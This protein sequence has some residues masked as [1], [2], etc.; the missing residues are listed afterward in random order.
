ML[1]FTFCFF[2]LSIG[3]DTADVQVMI[4]LLEDVIVFDQSFNRRDGKDGCVL[5]ISCLRFMVLDNVVCDHRHP[6]LGHI[7][8]AYINPIC[9]C[10][11]V[12][13]EITLHRLDVLNMEAKN[14]V[15]ED[16]I[17]DE[18][19]MY[20]FSEEHFCGLCDFSLRLSVDL[21]TRCAGKSEEL[22]LL[23]MPNNVL[24][25][26][27][28]LTAVTL[29]NDEDNFLVLI[30]IHNFCVLRTLHSVRHLLHRCDDELP[31]FVLHLFYK[32][33]SSISGINRTGFEFVELFCG[34][35][36]QVLPVYKEDN[37]FDIGVGCEDL[38]CLK[39]SQRLSCAGCMPN[40]SV[41]VSERGLPDKSLYCIHL[42][43]THHHEQLV[44]VIQDGVS[45]QHLDN[46]VS[47]KEGDRE[48]FQIGDTHIVEVRPE[49]GKTVKHIS[50]GVGKVFCINAIGHNEKLNEVVQSVVG[51]LFIAHHL[52]DSFSNIYA[53]PLQLHLNERKSIDKD[54]HII[55]ID[56]L[57]NNGCL[58][59]YLK[60]VLCVVGIEE[61]EVHFRSVL[62]LQHELISK[63]FCALE[64]RFSEHNVEHSLPFLRCQRV[65]E[66][67]SIED[68]KLCFEVLNQS[69][70][71][72]YRDAGVALLIELF[73]KLLF[74]GCFTLVCHIFI[75]YT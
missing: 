33:I 67:R 52:V 62:T 63:Y 64:N 18:I 72:W 41:A 27:T 10:G 34:L 44:R 15:V 1:I 49:E 14:I 39:G 16:S 47:G 13:V 3:E 4:D 54:R 58:V 8:F 6:F 20:A 60:N 61:G 48:L 2:V 22:S 45:R 21:K 38:C 29:I 51:M 59:C 55:T 69:V 46:M 30:G 37:L 68:C 56:I 74:K 31:V 26:I 23:E 50:V 25:H 11:I 40:I 53:T 24:V 57:P 73:Y 5:T 75:S 9:H 19:V 32:D 12:P 35:G 66:F 42:I 7:E 65:V 71:V 17:L 70:I 28:K 36:I 43:G